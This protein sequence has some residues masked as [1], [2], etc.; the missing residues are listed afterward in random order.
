[1]K[2]SVYEAYK[3]FSFRNIDNGLMIY[4]NPGDRYEIK[5]FDRN[6]DKVRVVSEDGLVDVWMAILAFATHFVEVKNAND[7]R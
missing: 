4:I 7:K 2:G 5:Q 3:S 1:M 6:E